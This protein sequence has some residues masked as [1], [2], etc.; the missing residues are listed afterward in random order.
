MLDQIDKHPVPGPG[1]ISSWKV[2]A[3]DKAKTAQIDAKVTIAMYKFDDF[4]RKNWLDMGEDEDAE[5]LREEVE[6]LREEY[7]T[8]IREQDTER[9][10]KVEREMEALK[11]PYEQHI[12]RQKQE[13]AFKVPKMDMSAAASDPTTKKMLQGMQKVN[14][15]SGRSDDDPPKDEPSE[16]AP[17]PPGPGM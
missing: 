15:E 11:S 10:K 4:F 7:R 8:S 14:E 9:E 17:A 1:R 3:D 6:K 12:E 13:Q 16:P 2:T 5:K